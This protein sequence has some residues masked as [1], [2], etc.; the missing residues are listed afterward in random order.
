MTLLIVGDAEDL[1]SAYLRMVAEKAGIDVRV[2]PEENYGSG[3]LPC[4]RSEW[5]RPGMGHIKGS[6]LDINFSAIKGTFVRF[7][8]HPAIPIELGHESGLDELYAR[9][10]R[11]AIHAFLQHVPGT[12]ANLPL[13][14][15][16]NGSKPLQMAELASHGFKIPRWICSNDSRL[17]ED[18]VR[19]CPHGAVVKSLS[20]TRS[21]VKLWSPELTERISCGSPPVLVQ[22]RITGTDL[23][24]HVVR[25]HCFPTGIEV[26]AADQVDYRFATTTP[27]YKAVQAP[28]PIC[29]L[30]ISYTAASGLV[31]S[32]FD[33]RV[34]P[35]GGLWCLECNPAPTFM[36]YE[37]ATAQPIASS[38][39][40]AMG[41]L[42][43]LGDSH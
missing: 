40:A 24:L 1:T 36:P 27:H 8:P 29:R 34:D 28:E 4:Y 38:L 31:I 20:G 10:R 6:N 11:A 7:N 43:A 23:R 25:N 37:L 14:G 26:E 41:L 13:H 16:S 18:F 39:L 19:E 32:G 30:A 35:N 5:A 42:E 2:L 9:E 22:S 15:Q 12:V 3:W 21:E 17:I 33:F